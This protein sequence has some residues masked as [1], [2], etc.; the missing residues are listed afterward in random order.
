MVKCADDK[1]IPMSLLPRETD[2]PA[3]QPDE[4]AAGSSIAGDDVQMWDVWTHGTLGVQLP[5]LQKENSRPSRVRSPDLHDDHAFTSSFSRSCL[6][7]AVAPRRSMLRTPFNSVFNRASSS[8]TSL[9][10]SSALPIISSP[11][12]TCS[13][14]P[15][16]IFIPFGI[17][18]SMSLAFIG[19]PRHPLSHT[20]QSRTTCTDDMSVEFI[21][22]AANLKRIMY[23]TGI[24]KRRRTQM[25]VSATQRARSYF[26]AC[27][28][29]DGTPWIICE[30]Q[31]KVEIAALR[32]GFIGFDLKPGTSLQEAEKL[33]ELL[34][35]KFTEVSVTTFNNGR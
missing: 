34:R 9:S 30:P 17:R 24:A 12:M 22:T 7:L 21:N 1:T 19:S 16:L 6:R 5:Q 15:I 32:G 13:R 28:T 18:I 2:D 4:P 23:P 11:S 8:C 35:G 29:S 26:R 27:E 10:T 33:A 25:T 14:V 20:S 31:G 3:G